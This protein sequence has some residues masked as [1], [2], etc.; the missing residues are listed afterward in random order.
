MDLSALTNPTE[1][2]ISASALLPH[3]GNESQ[4]TE[5]EPETESTTISETPAKEEARDTVRE[6]DHNQTTAT[7]TATANS[8]KD[9]STSE[10]RRLYNYLL[11]KYRNATHTSTVLDQFEGYLRNLSKYQSLRNNMLVNVLKFINDHETL[12]PTNADENSADMRRLHAIESKNENLKPL[13][14]NLLKLENLQSQCKNARNNIENFNQLIGINDSL[15]SD[16]AILE[17]STFPDLYS[18]N[19]DLLELVKK[20]QCFAN[21]ASSLIE[22]NRIIQREAEATIKQIE[23]D[24]TH[25]PRKRKAAVVSAQVTSQGLPSKSSESISTPVSTHDDGSPS[26]RIK[27][28]DILT[29]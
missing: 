16:L 23:K 6:D 14:E 1:T 3:P 29:N 17:N 7:V 18:G 2:D 10:Y 24:H 22:L 5:T 12:E 28:E 27:V 26:K 9:R 4:A 25:H 8:A 21:E 15:S 20:N 11:E 13:V 19:F